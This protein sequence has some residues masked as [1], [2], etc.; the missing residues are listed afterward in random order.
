VILGVNGKP[1]RSPEEL[2][3]AIDQAGKQAALLVQR[4]EARIFVPV[5]IG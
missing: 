4:G 2:K 5:Q 3:Q 1:V